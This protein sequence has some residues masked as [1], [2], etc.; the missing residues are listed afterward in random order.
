MWKII[1]PASTCDKNI[2]PVS[3]SNKIIE[4]IKY[5]LFIDLLLILRD[6]KEIKKQT[7]NITNTPPKKI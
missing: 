4:R 6:S 2:M 1:P 3:K 7:E 5:A